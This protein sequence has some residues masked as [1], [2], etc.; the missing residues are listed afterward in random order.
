MATA[1]GYASVCTATTAAELDAALHALDESQ[2]GPAAAPRGAA[3]VEARLALGTRPDL[4]RP[5]TTPAVAKAD[6]MGFLG[7]AA[8]PR[9]GGGGGGG[10][11]SGGAAPSAAPV[12]ARSESGDPFLLTPGPLTTSLSTKR[13][14]LHDLGSRDPA[15]V[16]ATARVRTQLLGV[17]EGDNEGDKGDAAMPASH[18]LACVPLQGSG[19]YAVEAMVTQLGPAGGTP[20]WSSAFHF[21]PP[22]GL[23]GPA[24]EGLRLPTT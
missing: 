9:G 12:P 11:V 15:F 22:Q 20:G 19:T 8:A 17:L 13:A 4:G 10:A 6:F 21:W 7:R 18:S 1:A 3:F 2:R 24:S 5:K 14:M 23:I 16:R